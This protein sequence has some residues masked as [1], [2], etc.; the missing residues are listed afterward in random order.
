MNTYSE[1]YVPP[2]G[3]NIE[4]KVSNAAKAWLNTPVPYLAKDSGNEICLKKDGTLCVIYIVKDAAS[5]D[6]SVLQAMNEVKDDFVSKIERGISFSFV[7]LDATAE[8]EFFSM[9][10]L[11]TSDLPAMVVLN[12]GKRKRFL[13]HENNLNAEGLSKTLDTILGGDAKFK[14]IKDFKSLTT[15]FEQYIS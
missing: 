14:A 13:K 7:R 9:F 2:G 8:S 10:N 11:E 4:V 3:D 15:Q 12:P 6:N 1:T 5:S